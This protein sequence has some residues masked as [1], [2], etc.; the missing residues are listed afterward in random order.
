L[1]YDNVV[2]GLNT[3]MY[4]DNGTS[5]APFQTLL[6]PYLT[7]EYRIISMGFEVINTT[8]ELNVQGLVT[9][10]RQ[11]VANI[12]SAKSILVTEGPVLSSGGTVSTTP[13]AYVDALLSNTPPATPGEALLLDGSKQWKAKD[14]CYVVPTLNSPE[15]PSGQNSTS[16][17]LHTSIVDPIQTTPGVNWIY[18]TPASGANIPAA[19]DPT[20]VTGNPAA[21]PNTFN[22]VFLPT[23][24]V[25]MQPFNGAGAYFSGLSNS[26][27]LQL[28]AIYYI[29]RF[30]TQQ[31]SDLVVLA[32]RSCHSDSVA[33][34]LY[35]EIIREMPVGVPQRMN[36]MG[37][38]FA[39]A[40]SAAAD[41]VSPVLSAIPL[42]MAQTI[43]SGVKVA[44]NMAKSLGSKKESPGQ[45]YSS[46]G[47]NVSASVSKKK[48]TVVGKKNKKGGLIKK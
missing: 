35:S 25:W 23:G 20:P 44:G 1:V 18:V 14:G 40:V 43:A 2:S 26:T 24:G 32:R 48:S 11:P 46:T 10:Y 19:F 39:D 13:F 47:S 28:N 15:N 45:T 33:L 31:D 3:F 9:C 38:W 6:A 30:P 16:P 5:V 27:T 37:E 17:I 21:T 22:L 36:G 12:D 29:E 41:F 34:D 42:P 7:G 4:N 8:A